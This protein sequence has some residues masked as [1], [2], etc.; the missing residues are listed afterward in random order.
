MSTIILGSQSSVE[1]YR[2]TVAA[3]DPGL[4]AKWADAL[5]RGV[6]SGDDDPADDIKAARLSA[7]NQRRDLP[8]KRECFINA[9]SDP[10][11]ALQEITGSGGVVDN[12]FAVGTGPVW[13][14]G[15]H[16]AL[17]SLIASKYGCP[18]GRPNDWA[19]EAQAETQEG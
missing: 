14:E 2:E 18:V 8:G 3:D 9:S 13:V 17:V 1:A 5:S 10:L 6:V 7:I 11:T 16:D 4:A 12:H 15:D 19:T